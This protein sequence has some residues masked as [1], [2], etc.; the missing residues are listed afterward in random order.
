[1]A[2][3]KRGTKARARRKKILNMA[4]GFTHRRKNTIRRG[5]EAVDR[6]KRYAYRDRKDKKRNYRELWINR[7]NAASNELGLAYS[8]LIHGLK[9]SNIEINRKMLSD[10]AIKD[11]EAFNELTAIAKS[12]LTAH[13]SR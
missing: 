3:A 9:V 7:I 2:R 6:A 4:E 8:R 11:P 5:A 13:A 12:A 1:M 10:M